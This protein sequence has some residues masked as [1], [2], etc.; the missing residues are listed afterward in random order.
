MWDWRFSSRSA[1][2]Q[3]GS[4]FAHPLIGGSGDRIWGDY[5]GKAA[6]AFP[7]SSLKVKLITS[8]LLGANLGKIE[9]GRFQQLAWNQSPATEIP[10]LILWANKSWAMVPGGNMVGDT[11]HI[12]LHCSTQNISVSPTGALKFSSQRSILQRTFGTRK[13]A[14]ICVCLFRKQLPWVKSSGK[15]GKWH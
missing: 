2:L 10:S 6:S 4:F 14:I 9:W 12:S 8:A 7:P 3:P 5:Q 1:L 13:Q 15:Q 11:E